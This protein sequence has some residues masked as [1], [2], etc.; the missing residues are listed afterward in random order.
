[1]S[2]KCIGDGS[3][4]GYSFPKYLLSS[5]VVRF[6]LK[7]RHSTKKPPHANRLFSEACK[8]F[9]LTWKV[10]VTYLKNPDHLSLEHYYPIS[11]LYSSIWC[12]KMDVEMKKG[13]CYDRLS[14]WKAF[15]HASRGWFP[16]EFF[17]K[18]EISMN[19]FL[20]ILGKR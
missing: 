20:K 9:H 6:K 16:K 12:Y 15:I 1:M 5:K 18:K 7:Y 11:I 3:I 2:C 10:Y 13:I 4:C 17:L 14:E 8:M 19:F